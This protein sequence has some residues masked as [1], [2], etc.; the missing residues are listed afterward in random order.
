MACNCHGTG[1][2]V[3][4]TAGDGI[5][6]AGSGSAS[7]PYLISSKLLDHPLLSVRD[8]DTVNLTLFGSGAVDD[9]YTLSADTG[10][11]TALV[12]LS[13]VQSPSPVAGVVPT[14]VGAPIGGHFEFQPNGVYYCTTATR[15]DAAHRYQG[16][17]IKETNTGKRYEWDGTTWVDITPSAT[18]TTFAAGNLTGTLLD[19]T[20]PARIQQ[21]GQLLTNVDLNTVQTT[22]WFRGSA[23]TNQPQGGSDW[24]FYQVQAHGSGSTANISQTAYRYQSTDIWQRVRLNNGTWTAW[25]HQIS[26]ASAAG[27]DP[28]NDNR[29]VQ[30]SSKSLIQSATVTFIPS[31]WVAAG[32][33]YGA[34]LAVTFSKPFATVPQIALTPHTGA[35]EDQHWG[36]VNATTTGF[37]YYYYRASQQTGNVTADWVAIGGV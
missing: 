34:H 4:I 23:L 29:Y 7:N 32:A 8:S 5:D 6:V 31:M 14:W 26:T 21:Y 16:L 9:P 20:L 10:A 17:Q 22:G 19:S 1:I 24:W 37:T 28:H 11:A 33:G 35:S 30:T 27:L 36:I 3:Q 12:N 18:P 25:D 15:P 13:D 2:G